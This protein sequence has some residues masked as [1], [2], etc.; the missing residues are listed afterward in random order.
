MGKRIIVLGLAALMFSIGG[1]AFA[2]TMVTLDQAISHGVSEIEIRLP[3]GTRVMVL[4]F[5]SSSRRLSNYV[6]DQMMTIFARNG[7]LRVTEKADLEFVLQELNFQRS[8][9][10][11]DES[12]RSIGRILGAQYVISGTIEEA[13]SNYVVQFRTMAVEPGASQNLTRVGVIKDEQIV[14]MMAADT[15]TRIRADASNITRADISN[16]AEGDTSTQTGVDISSLRNKVVLSVGGGVYGKAEILHANPYTGGFNFDNFQTDITWFFGAPLFFNAELFSYLLL[17]VSPFYLH[18]FDSENSLNA[19]G[20]AFSLFGQLPMQITDRITLYP[21]FGVG[22]EMFIY[23][24]GKDFK[25]WRSDF[26]NDY[27]SLYLKPGLGLNYNLIG[28]LRLN[29]RFVW[30]FLL[31]SRSATT[32]KDA[33]KNYGFE[34]LEL[35]HA[36]SLFLG[37]NYVFLSF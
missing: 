21:L 30:N 32:R 34:Y 8:G 3:Q 23:A 10:I 25:F 19:I 6:L 4:D 16:I 5:N 14:D 36:L 17:D 33:I 31:Y 20:T 22:Y 15:S 2:Q 29:A 24:W 28:N 11:N 35:Q 13:G 9:N 1:F 18:V 37:L 7:K 27:D 12:A 26:S